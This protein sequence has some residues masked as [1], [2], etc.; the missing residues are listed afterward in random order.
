MFVFLSYSRADS[1]L[2]M[3]LKNDLLGHGV[4]VWIDREG[5]QPGTLDWE[6]AL[7]TAIRAARAVLL[8]ASPNA[9]SSRYVKDELRIAE[10][11]QRPVYPLWI[12]GTQWIDAV[13]LGW[14]G[15]QYLDARESRYEMAV[16]ELVALLTTA[17]PTPAKVPELA[18]EP[19]NP[20]KGLRA[21]LTLSA[22]R[23]LGGV[24][25]ALT[26]QAEETYTALPSEEHRQLARALFAR[27]VDLGVSEQDTTRR[28][29]ALSEFVLTDVTSTRL[30]RE[31]AEAF[32]KARLLT[33]NE[34]AGTTTIEVSHEAVIREWK[35]LAGWI[36]ETREDI[37]LLQVIREDAAELSLEEEAFLQA[38]AAEQ[39]RQEALL[40]ERHIQ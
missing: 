5:L 23:E 4:Q 34:I 16:P 21:L 19:R 1:D 6:E 35:R 3:R 39:A 10:M 29:A 11:Y 20:Y 17:S 25:G 13:P 14:G 7:R 12:A 31:T 9:R 27:L 33:T 2:V 15:A 8:M 22:Y 24:K 36:R 37:Y 40:A 26:K 32:I 38:S 30:L 18:F 28:R